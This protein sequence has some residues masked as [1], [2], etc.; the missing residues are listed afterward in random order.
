MVLGR[1]GTFRMVV[2][3]RGLQADHLLLSLS[4]AFSLGIVTNDR[5]GEEQFRRQFKFLDNGKRLMGV[6]LKTALG[7]NG[8]KVACH[9]EIPSLGEKF[10]CHLEISRHD[11]SRGADNNAATNTNGKARQ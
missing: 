2:V 11:G 7:E 4:Q 10:Y 3:P 6:K 9:G 1:Y 5:F 8:R